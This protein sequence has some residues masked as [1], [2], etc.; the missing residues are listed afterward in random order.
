MQQGDPLGPLAFALALHPIVERIKHEVPGLNINAWYLDDGTLCG[1]AADLSAALAIIEEDGPSR[2]LKLNRKKSL[3]YIP[4]DASFVANPLPPEIPFVRSGFDLLG[5]P[6]GPPSHCEASMMKRVLK[7]QEILKRLPDLQDSQMECTILRYCLALPKISFALLRSCPPQHV[8]NAISAFDF[9]MLEALSDLAGGPLPNWSWLKASLPASLGGLGICQASFHATAAYIGSLDQSK[10]LVAR[11]LG[12][13]PASTNHMTHALQ[14]L[15]KNAGR[16]DWTSIED[17][18]VPLRQRHLSKAIDQ[19]VFDD[20]C[21]TA[22]NTRFKALALSSSIPHAGD[23]LNVVPSTALGLHLFDWE[24]RLCLQYWLGL[25][26]VS[27]GTRCP[28]CNSL[29]DPFGDHQ[30][31]CGGNGDRIH[32]HDSLRDALYS[33]AQSAALAPRRE[34]PSLI[35]GSSSRPAD[36]FLPQW[37][38]GQPAAIDV[39]V[40]STLQQLTVVGASTTKG[41]ALSVGEERKRAAHAEACHSVG[42]SFIPLVIESLGGWSDQAA[43]TIRCFG[44][45]LGQRL[46]TDTADT[47]THL[48]QRLSIRLWRGNAIMW[49]RRIPTRAAEVDGIQ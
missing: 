19:A 26:M 45:L 27:E 33:A 46:G 31:G 41:H 35:P 42:V 6:I 40:I 29:V 15:A 9:S 47:T 37:K 17:V 11:I 21:A 30:V 18:D 14:D 3:L 7:V 23:W 16:D 48:F 24:Y 20:L 8:K 43:D 39:T 2:G 10:Q 12:R 36:V 34:V 49:V 38:R 1:S 5:S 13:V 22:P 32:R 28:V 4:E 44:R 25:R